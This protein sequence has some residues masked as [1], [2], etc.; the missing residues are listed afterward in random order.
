MWCHFA[1]E[2][3]RDCSSQSAQAIQSQYLFHLYNKKQKQK[4]KDCHRTE[5][6]YF[7]GK[8]LNSPIQSRCR[9]NVIIPLPNAWRITIEHIFNSFHS[10]RTLNNEINGKKNG[11]TVMAN[12]NFHQIWFLFHLVGNHFLK[13]QYYGV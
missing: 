4:T 6:S 1:V 3:D 5:N 12:N 8:I 7:I 2:V 11:I 13:Q 9:L 10:K